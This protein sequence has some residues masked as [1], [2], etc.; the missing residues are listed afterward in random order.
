MT[1]MN[2]AGTGGLA[3]SA[4]LPLRSAASRGGGEMPTQPDGTPI[5]SL[6]TASALVLAKTLQRLEQ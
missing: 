1:P 4:G 3:D 6:V 5:H 2:T